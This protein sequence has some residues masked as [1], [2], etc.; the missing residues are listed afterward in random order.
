MRRVGALLSFFLLAACAMPGNGSLGPDDG[1]PEPV[2]GPPAGIVGNG[3]LAMA[4][5]DRCTGVQAPVGERIA[6]C[7][8]LIQS[9]RLGAAD[10][11]VAY[12]NRSSQ[13]LEKND[14]ARSLA[15]S[16][17][18]IRLDPTDVAAYT[19][20]G[21]ALAEMERFDEA[22]A[23]QDQA[24]AID[25]RYAGAFNN[26]GAVWSAKGDPLRAITDFDTAIRLDP[27]FAAAYVN[28][29]NAAF[30]LGRFAQAVAD[31]Q[32]G[33]GLERQPYAAL[34]L[35]LA[36]QR[37]LAQRAAGS[38]PLDAAAAPA[39]AAALEDQPWPLPL[40]AMLVN[41]LDEDRLRQ[42]VR[43]DDW[44]RLPQRLCEVAFYAGQRYLTL[45]RPDDARPR[46]QEATE[47]CPRSG[48]EYQGAR[49]EL[50]R[51]GA[52]TARR[53]GP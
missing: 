46:L 39:G 18:A 12:H 31:Y 37:D 43:Q 20:R 14:S 4:D 9:G 33:Q 28:R 3:P 25:P 34:W 23:A 32:T 42:L 26:R 15:D 5:Y 48:P 30:F 29:G 35:H 7:T 22:L 53:G 11:A 50:L 21:I 52:T 13:F 16:G 40:A 41:A 51:L 44:T 10:L 6:G 2:A 27:G 49:A 36:T 17:E 24:I 45:R 47:R 1:L 38:G 8:R 19:N